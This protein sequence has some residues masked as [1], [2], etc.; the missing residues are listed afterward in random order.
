MAK[1][2]KCPECGK[3]FVRRNGRHEYCSIEC[4]RKSYVKPTRLYYHCEQCGV[5]FEEGRLTPYCSDKCKRE[6][7][8]KPV[9]KATRKK[10]LSLDEVVRLA[11]A[12]GLTYGQYIVKYGG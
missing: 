1:E 2:V 5:T 10:V 9:K 8:G 4:R 6:A 7:E 3:M 11:K 12:E